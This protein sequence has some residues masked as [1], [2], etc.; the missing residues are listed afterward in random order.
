[1]WHVCSSNLIYEGDG[2]VH[3]SIV[4]HWW[5]LLHPIVGS[6]LITVYNCP[7]MKMLLNDGQQSSSISLLYLL[8]YMYIPKSWDKSNV[9]HSKHPNLFCWRMSLVSL[10]TYFL[11]NGML[12]NV[13][14]QQFSY[15]LTLYLNRDSSIWTMC[16]GPPRSTYWSILMDKQMSQKY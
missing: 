16:P 1:M 5:K 8:A 4:C 10:H 13:T 15:T 6:P 14:F 3:G 7:R 11:S 2:V 12:W 9:N